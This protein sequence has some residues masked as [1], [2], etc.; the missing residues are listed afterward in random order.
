MQFPN[1]G[2]LSPCIII[3]SNKW[4]NQM[5]QSLRLDGV[6]LTHSDFP[7][8]DRPRP[9]AL[10][11]PRSNGKPEAATAVDKLLMMGMKMTETYWV[12]FKRQAINLRDWCIWLVHLF[13]YITMHRLKNPKFGKGMQVEMKSMLSLGNVCYSSSKN[14]LSSWLLS[15]NIKSKIY[16]TKILSV[17][18]MVLK[19]GLP[20]SGKNISWCCSV[21]SC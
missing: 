11:P 4:T 16:R 21:I 15:E 2:F 9:T 3:Y 8:P 14:R 5:H 12:V 13:E 19:I 6:L 7:Q 20:C 10:L 18:Y 1:L 17:A